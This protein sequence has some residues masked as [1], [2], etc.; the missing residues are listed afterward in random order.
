MRS[1]CWLPLKYEDEVV[2]V[3]FIGKRREKGFNETE[4][5]MLLQLASQIAAAVD[6][7][8]ALRHIANLSDRLKK[9]REYLE[10]ELRTEFNFGE[11]IGESLA[12]KRVLKQVETVGPTDATVLIQGD[13][14]T[15]KEL[16][17]RAIHNLSPRRERTFIKLNCSAIP[18][19]LLES[20]LF[21]HEK[22]AFTGAIAQRIGRMELAHQG[23]LFLDEIGDLSLEL[24]PKLL[25]ALQEKEIE[26]LGG[27][28]TIPVD[29]R[30]IA[31]TNR[32]LAKMVKEGQFRSDLYYRLKVFP[33]TIPSL[34]QRHGDIPLLVNYFVTKHAR[35]MK[36]NINVIPENVMAALSR[37]HWPGNVRE[38]ENFIERAVILT[39]GPVLHAPLAELELA[40]EMQA[41]ASA[42]LRTTEREHILRVLRETKGAIGGPGGAAE[43]LG[44]KRTTLNSKLKKLGIRK[45]DYT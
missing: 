23:T 43:R 3:L 34:Q 30:L 28:R 10:E 44:L 15:G 45:E 4:R 14:G 24:Q 16:I 40:E 1:G 35:R 6:H 13:T 11:I 2:G 25:R 26:R 5:E 42:N 19:G 21:G 39:Q 22:G 12:L 18:L 27:K 29:V 20:E 9:E 32:D 17:A 36:K 7:I 33:I 8:E 41:P 31:A 37:W 38:L